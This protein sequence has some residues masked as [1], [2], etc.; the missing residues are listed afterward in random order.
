M[1]IKKAERIRKLK[2]N[3]K[4]SLYYLYSQAEVHLQWA[5]AR[6]KFE[7]YIPAAYEFVKAYYLLEKNSFIA[8]E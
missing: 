1:E 5:F 6:L 8:K 2:E 3:D 7:D 4:D